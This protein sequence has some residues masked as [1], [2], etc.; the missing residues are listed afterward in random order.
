M[1]R[2]AQAIFLLLVFT[3]CVD[4]QETVFIF[5]GDSFSKKFV[6]SPPNGDK[7]LE[8][9]RESESFESWTKLIGF[10][11]Q[12]LP[13]L[14]NDPEKAARALAQ[15]VKTTN[16]QAQVQVMANK[17][18]HEALVNFVTWPPDAKYMEFN[19][20]RYVQSEDGKALVSLQL[21][22]RFKADNSMEGIAKLWN[23]RTSWTKMAAEFNMKDVHAALAQ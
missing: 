8:F 2:V 9:V 7:L 4:A 1:R 10:R 22:Y 15:V 5:D 6:G 14:E 3:Q 21:A 19:V 13:K 18:T 20:F 17:Q 12:Q 16:P 11:Y 23:I